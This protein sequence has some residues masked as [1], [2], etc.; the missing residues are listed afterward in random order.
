MQIKPDEDGVAAETLLSEEFRLQL[1]EMGKG[2]AALSNQ[3][4]G[5]R[6]VESGIVRRAFSD[7]FARL[8]KARLAGW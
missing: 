8:E 3:V 2:M 7:E 6:G 4:A 5:M 1:R